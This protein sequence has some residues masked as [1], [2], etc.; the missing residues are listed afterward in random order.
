MYKLTFWSALYL[1]H[2]LQAN[3]GVIICEGIVYQ[4]VL[5]K[6]LTRGQI[7]YNAS[8]DSTRQY[9][10]SFRKPLDEYAINGVVYISIPSNKGTE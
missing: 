6:N 3:M 2:R 4:V 5:E 7:I 9:A 10:L 1:S 8:K